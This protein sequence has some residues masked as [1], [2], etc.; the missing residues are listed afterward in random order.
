MECTI[1]SQAD[2]T[3]WEISPQLPTS[4]TN[5]AVVP[6]SVLRGRGYFSQLGAVRTKPGRADSPVS[7]SKSCSDKLSL[8]QCV[9][10]LL[11]PTCYIISPENAY[12]STVTLPRSELSTVA[13]TRAFGPEGRMA[14]LRGRCWGAGYKFVPF[15]VKP[16][17]EGFMYSK[18]CAG[19]AGSNISAVW[20]GNRGGETLIGGVLQGKKQFSGT[21]AGSMLCKVKLWKAVADVARAVG[22][23]AGAAAGVPALRNYTHVKLSGEMETRQQVK[24][25]AR[26]VLGGWIRNKGDDIDVSEIES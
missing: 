9:S 15:E 17:D 5:P 26:R 20:V 10:V 16:T 2:P 19:L 6:P 8:R 11:S 23:G 3:P 13:C 18:R 4:P 14:P 12:I 7:L 21:K 22:A 25:E 24:D 1:A